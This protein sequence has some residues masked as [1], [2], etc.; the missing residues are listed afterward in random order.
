MMVMHSDERG[1]HQERTPYPRAFYDERREA[2]LEATRVIVPRLLAIYQPESVIDVGCGDGAWLSAFIERGITD[3]LGIDGAHIDPAALT[4]P[5]DRFSPHDLGLPLQLDRTFDL[6][7]CLEV[8]EHLPPEQA[9]RLIDTLCRLAPV[10]LFSAAIP[11]QWG[12]NHINCQ[13]PWYWHARFRALGYEVLD[14]LRP[15]MMYDQTVAFWYRQNMFLLVRQSALKSHASLVSQPVVPVE[16]QLVLVTDAILQDHL[17]LRPTVHRL[18]DLLV[19][20][21][22]RR[23]PWLP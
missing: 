17:R 2:V 7:I 12:T 1:P 19:E 11:G 8:A 20:R 21:V 5:V 9:D 15:Q 23:L 16:G 3:V 14:P 10:V 6:A 13:W 18:K 4:I 22:R